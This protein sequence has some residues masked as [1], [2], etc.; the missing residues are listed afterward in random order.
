MAGRIYNVPPQAEAIQD[1]KNNVTRF[2]V[3]ARNALPQRN[4]VRYRTSLVL[5][6]PDKVGAL[7]N[8]LRSFQNGRLTCAKL[9]LV[10][11]DLKHGITIFL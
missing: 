9:N 3:V 5:S 8:A 1:R 11:V 7:K 4:S 10:L 6:L 2:L